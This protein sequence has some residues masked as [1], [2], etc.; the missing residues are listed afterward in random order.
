MARQKLRTALLTWNGSTGSGPGPTLCRGHRDPRRGHRTGY[1]RRIA[2]TCNRSSRKCSSYLESFSTTPVCSGR[3]LRSSFRFWAAGSRLSKKVRLKLKLSYEPEVIL[4]KDDH[5]VVC[6]T[7][8]I[9]FARVKGEEPWFVGGQ[10]LAL[11]KWIPDF[12][13]APQSIIKT[14]VWMRLPNLPLQYWL[15]SLSRSLQVGRGILCPW[16]ILLTS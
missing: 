14:V 12:Q 13:S 8:V 9:D 6:L 16:T 7:S 15:P 10:L 3:A 1:R 2:I 4:V 11:D 5:F